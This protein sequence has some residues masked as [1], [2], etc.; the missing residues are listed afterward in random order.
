MRPVKRNLL[1]LVGAIALIY[2]LLGSALIVNQRSFI[3]VPFPGAL[4]PEEAKL[5]NFVRREITA[6]DGKPIIYWES[7]GDG[8]EPTLFYFHGNAGG[9]HAFVEPIDH[10]NKQGF[11]VIAMEYRGYP[12]APRGISQ[13]AIVS[14]GVT[15]IDAVKKSRP[16]QPVAIWGWSLGSG[17]ATQVAAERNPKALVLETPF[18][19]V[20]DLAGEITPFLPVRWLMR[21]TFLSRDAIK[22]VHSPVFIIHGDKDIVVPLHHA[23]AL[24]EAA[25]EPKTIEVYPGFTHF[26]L[27]ESPGFPN[28]IRFLKTELKR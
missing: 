16:N 17:V 14:D 7:T 10:L 5:E 9:L 15:L 20:V 6:P 13:R 11:H 26:N 27:M 19:A 23:K 24:Y 8:H 3:Y 22:R 28:A 18:T 2:V 21:D 12:G 25:N 1:R 4:T